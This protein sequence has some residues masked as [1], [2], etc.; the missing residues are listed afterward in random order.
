MKRI[1]VLLVAISMFGQLLAQKVKNI[2]GEYQ[3]RVERNQTIEEAY[4]YVLEQAK[5]KA[6]ADEFG[7]SISS[8]NL[9]SISNESGGDGSKTKMN[10][11]SFSDSFVNG[12]WLE[13]LTPPEYQEHFVNGEL[14]I[15][16]T[17]HGKAREVNK[18]V[19]GFVAETLTCPRLNCRSTEFRNHEDFY[20][21]F[22]SPVKGY[23][24]VYL[25]DGANA[26]MLLPYRGMNASYFEILADQSYILFDPATADPLISNIVDEYKM[27]TL[28]GEEINRL[29]LIFSTEPYIKGIVSKVSQGYESEYKQKEFPPYM[30]SKDFHVW[31]LKNRGANEDFF[32]KF[33]DISIS[34]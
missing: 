5:I 24:S 27:I 22:Q 3:V 14:W 32:V 23:L 7:T 6:M 10:F 25:D 13:T 30:S 19:P 16:C 17:V 26:Q 33:I 4:K 11:Q 29:W 28:K 8:S 20:I 15:K 9:T 18:P 31:L 34:Q 21:R 12:E 2:S 1:A